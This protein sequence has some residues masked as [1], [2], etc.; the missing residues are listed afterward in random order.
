MPK[1]VALPNF[2]CRY[3]ILLAQQMLWLGND[4]QMYTASNAEVS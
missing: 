2:L 4:S 3:L 1:F